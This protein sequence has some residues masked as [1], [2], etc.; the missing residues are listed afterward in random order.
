MMSRVVAVLA[1]AGLMSA[2]LTQGALAQADYPSK[3][4]TLIVPYP[5][6]GGSDTM[7][8]TVAEKLGETLGVRI[9]IENS[10]SG[11]GTVGTRTAAKAAPDGYTLLLGHTGTISINPTLYTN[12]GYDPDKDFV[13]MGTIA[14]IQLALVT[15]PTFPAKSVKEFIDMAKKSPGT[16]AMG[17]SA[18]GTGSY[19]SAQLFTS[20]TGVNVNIISYRGL[21]PFLTDIL[22]GHVPVG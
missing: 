11:G 19:M 13:P 10:G 20:M 22:G 12:P 18:I 1:A 9:I 7:A 16:I 5:A 14:R 2:V 3:P 6:G 21:A 4:V 15:H 8:R 17:A